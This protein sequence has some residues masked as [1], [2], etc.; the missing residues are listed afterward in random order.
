M[1]GENAE[2]MT[3]M[4]YLEEKLIASECEKNELQKRNMSLE[5]HQE[6]QNYETAAMKDTCATTSRETE[7]KYI[8]TF[9]FF[10]NIYIA[11]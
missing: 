8:Q 2:L 5:V 4:K 11:F 9:I 6:E 10:K 1:T 3:Q 7:V